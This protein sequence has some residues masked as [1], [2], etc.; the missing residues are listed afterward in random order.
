ML[1]LVCSI[2][3]RGSRRNVHFHSCTF[4]FH[5]ICGQVKL[6]IGRHSNIKRTANKIQCFVCISPVTAVASRRAPPR[7][8][9]QLLITFI[10]KMHVVH[11]IY[12]TEYASVASPVSFASSYY[13]ISLFRDTFSKH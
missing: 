10:I 12:G 4:K 2:E 1:S 5:L 9:R 13:L 3:K 8:E 6:L 7:R 11:Q